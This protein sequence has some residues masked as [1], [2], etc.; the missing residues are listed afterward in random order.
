[1]DKFH[2]RVDIRESGIKIDHRTKCL[3]AG[4]CF[5]DYIGKIMADYKF[6]VLLNPFGTLFNPVSIS[7][8]IRLL[9]RNKEFTGNDLYF[10]NDQWISFSHYTG[11]SGSDPD[12]S[13]AAI[14]KGIS[15]GSSWL[16]ETEFLILT[17]GTA[18]V[19]RFNETGSIV[20][21]CHKLPSSFFKK[22]LVKPGEIFS[23]YRNLFFELR[24]FNPRLKVIFTLSPVRHWSDGAINN[25]L[26]KSTLHYAIQQMVKEFENAWYFPAYEIFMDELRDYRFY[27]SDM[28]HPSETGTR[29]VWDRFCETWVSDESTKIMAELEPVIKALNHRP[30]NP[31][32]QAHKKFRE[33]TQ[34]KIREFSRKYPFLGF[35]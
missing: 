34:N 24:T 19:Y 14:N 30:V 16:K 3:L 27:A 31:D 10:Y 23:D 7:K 17:F 33:N 11:F 18:W 4:S 32:S 35:E 28:L 29:Y 21:N 6:P 20:A 12:E 13:L 15:E 22:K 26:S 5:S 9:I 2:T 8:D 1:M 25:Q